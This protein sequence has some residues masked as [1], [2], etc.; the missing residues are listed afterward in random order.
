MQIVRSSDAS[1]RCK[2]NCIE[3]ITAKCG[4]SAKIKLSL[5]ARSKHYLEELAKIAPELKMTHV[6]DLARRVAC[7]RFGAHRPAGMRERLL[8]TCR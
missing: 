4:L 7:E 8:G 2:C 1:D 6:K 5:A 3:K